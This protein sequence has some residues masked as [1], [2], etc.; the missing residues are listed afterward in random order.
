LEI[1]EMAAREAELL[2]PCDATAATSLRFTLSA[3][4]E[5][6]A[7]DTLFISLNQMG[8]VFH[9]TVLSPRL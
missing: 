9:V 2:L 3:E 7:D 4:E 1:D 5:E 8:G 6:E